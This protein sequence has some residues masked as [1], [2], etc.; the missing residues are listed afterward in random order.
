MVYYP[1]EG[2]LGSAADMIKIIIGLST[3]KG[4]VL[5]QIPEIIHVN[6]HAPT[7]LDTLGISQSVK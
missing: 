1:N 3:S 4:S 6:N 7:T 5:A 2:F